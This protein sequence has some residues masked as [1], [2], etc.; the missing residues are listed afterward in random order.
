MGH[1]GGGYYCNKTKV[2]S[3]VEVVQ[4]TKHPKKQVFRVRK[5][6]VDLD[7]GEKEVPVDSFEVVVYPPDLR[8]QMLS[9]KNDVL[10]MLNILMHLKI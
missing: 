3:K 8:K 5:V 2:S 4:L 6:A 9:T 1:V 7:V 10:S